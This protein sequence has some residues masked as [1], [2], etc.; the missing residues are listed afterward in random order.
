MEAKSSNPSVSLA[1]NIKICSY[2]RVMPTQQQSS[3][4][5]QCGA[6]V[7]GF[8]ALAGLR[9]ADLARLLG[10]TQSSIS[11]R[12]AGRTPF[13][14]AELAILAAE[15]DVDAGDLIPPAVTA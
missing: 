4:A 9:Q 11:A 3:Y 1:V 5:A 10:L 13:T 8:A 7:G 6:L 12:L 15:F 2:M 14:V